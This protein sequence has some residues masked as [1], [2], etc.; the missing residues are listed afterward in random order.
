MTTRFEWRNQLPDRLATADFPHAAGEAFGRGM[1]ILHLIEIPPA[2]AASRFMELDDC[3]P[4]L[5]GVVGPTATISNRVSRRQHVV[6]VDLPRQDG[7]GRFDP[8]QRP[9]SPARTHRIR[10]RQICAC[11]GRQ[12]CST[13]CLIT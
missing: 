12:P 5:A 13:N 4:T 7:A 11:R 3:V 2:R 8:H 6:C 10:C 9:D 1:V